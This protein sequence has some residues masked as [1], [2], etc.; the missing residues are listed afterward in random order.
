MCFA[1]S[2]FSKGVSMSTKISAEQL[3]EIRES[4]QKV[5]EWNQTG[6]FENMQK[7]NIGSKL[8]ILLECL[9]F[10]PPLS[11]P[12]LH[13]QDVDGNG[14]ISASELGNLF[15][16]VRLSMP[17]YQIRELLEKLDKDSDS[18]ISFEEFTAVGNTNQLTN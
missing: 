6:S 8:K 18:H 11:C 17:G 5:G 1:V 2:L 13:P 7:S 15:H 9:P 16:E 3:E 12:A 4:F 14:Y 10:L